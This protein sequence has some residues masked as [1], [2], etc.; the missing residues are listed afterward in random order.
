MS[1]GV[2]A[3]SPD[4][5]YGVGRASVINSAL[6][7]CSCDCP[8]SS[9][10]PVCLHDLRCMPCW[11][12]H[13]AT[14]TDSMNSSLSMSTYPREGHVLK[15][16]KDDILHLHKFL[17]HQKVEQVPQGWFDVTGVGC[18]HDFVADKMEPYPGNVVEVGLE[19]VNL[20]ALVLLG[21]PSFPLDAQSCLYFFVGDA[22]EVFLPFRIGTYRVVGQTIQFRIW[23]L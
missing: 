23:I 15:G 19:D 4:M 14:L 11:E 8:S 12:P 13:S 2:A 17:C 21:P 5:K 22:V 20:S 9:G 16:S 1:S 18:G 6:A 7:I 3:S 10:S